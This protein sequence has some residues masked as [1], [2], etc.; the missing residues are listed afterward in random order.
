MSSTTR[1][2]FASVEGAA[3]LFTPAFL[4]YL[5]RL[6][7]QLD[8]SARTLRTKRGEVLKKAHAQ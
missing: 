2:K 8:Q 3:E 7:D 1:V 4:D 5:V 6:H